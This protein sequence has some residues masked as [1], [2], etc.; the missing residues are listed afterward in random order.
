MVPAIEAWVMTLF[1]AERITETTDALMAE[2]G[3]SLAETTRRSGL[4]RRVRDAE[5]KLAQFEDA[6]GK[7]ADPTH[8]VQWINDAALE[9]AGAQADRAAV[10]LTDEDASNTQDALMEVVAD[11]ASVAN[12]LSTAQASV[13]TALFTAL[14]LHIVHDHGAQEARVEIST[15]DA[16]GAW[17]PR[18]DLNPCLRESK[19]L[20]TWTSTCGSVRGCACVS[21]DDVLTC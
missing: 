4:D 18:G 9:L 16:C 15:Q 1:P 10:G 11:T 20:L 13:K 14:G 3:P 19:P 6:L 8:V 17:C 2:S 21:R 5:R 12:Q 7:G